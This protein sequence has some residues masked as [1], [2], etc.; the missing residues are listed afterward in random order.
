[1]GY[2]WGIVLSA[3]VGALLFLTPPRTYDAPLADFSAAPL[4]G[5]AP[6]EVVFRD[7]SIGAI[8]EFHWDFGD[9]QTGRGERAAH[10]YEQ[11]GRYVARLSITGPGGSSEK[12]CG[13]EVLPND[14][15]AA[16]FEGEPLKG[17][18]R[19]EV[20][21]R[22]LSKNAKAFAWDFGDGGS[23]DE[24]SPVHVYERPGLYGVKL[25]VTNDIGSDERVRDKYVKVAHP[26]EPLADFRATPR[27]GPA[28]L[29]VNF[30]HLCSGAVTEWR[31]DFGDIRSTGGDARFEPNP[32]HVYRAPGHY[33]VV[34]RVKG[35]HGEDEAEKVKYIHVKDEDRGQGKGGG[36]GGVTQA[37]KKP[38]RST[39]GAGDRPGQPFGPRTDR[40]KVTL[41]PVVVPPH[42][43][44]G[45]LVEKPKVFVGKLAGGGGEPREA[46]LG[47][48][49][50]L[51]QRAAEEAIRREPVPPAMRDA[52]RE[53][54]RPL[55]K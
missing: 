32:S 18:G 14:R 5:P 7:G 42:A 49:W 38:P 19:L 53:Y 40:P 9:G 17:R 41:D 47:E 8:D 21:F 26:D 55:P 33:T 15:A 20:R 13:V 10:V 39:G 31:W 44:G 1:V 27:E 16:D 43:P 6:L 12:T 25:R 22:N 37:P 52:V 35:P 54:F 51:S 45:D 48:V 30:E 50:P 24:E 46:P 11:P 3:A 29:A 23:S 4:R 28:P 34:L 2:R 36:G